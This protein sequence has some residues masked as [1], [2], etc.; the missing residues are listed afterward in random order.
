GAPQGQQIPATTGATLPPVRFPV[1][2]QPQTT[3][4]NNPA[5][6]TSETVPAMGTPAPATGTT[7]AAVTGNV[8]PF[9]P[10]TGTAPVSAAPAA[11]QNETAPQKVSPAQTTP[12]API[13]TPFPQFNG[14]SSPVSYRSESG[15]LHENTESSCVFFSRDMIIRGQ[16]PA[17]AKPDTAK[18]D[19]AK[20]DTAKPDKAKPDT[21]KPDQ[22][23]PDQ[24]KSDTV[25][26]DSVPMTSEAKK[27]AP[28]TQGTDDL[29]DS[30]AAAPAAVS[31]VSD[32]QSQQE[33][34]QVSSGQGQTGTSENSAFSERLGGRPLPLKFDPKLETTWKSLSRSTTSKTAVEVESKPGVAQSGRFLPET[35]P[36]TCPEESGKLPPYVSAKKA[37]PKYGRDGKAVPGYAP[38]EYIMDG[39]DSKGEA[40]ATPDWNVHHLDQEDTIAHFDTI[41]GRILV[42]PS[43]RVC[44]YSPRF[45]SVRQIIGL[46]ESD[47]NLLLHNAET[48]LGAV[49]SSKL[50]AV[51]VRSQ[52]E[53]VK[54][55]LVET[56]LSGMAAKDLGHS[57]SGEVAVMEN[58]Q[59]T[60]L[61]D[62][63]S[64][65]R[66]NTMSDKVK[67]SLAKGMQ[68]AQNWGSMESVK[69]AVGEVFATANTYANSP[70]TMYHVENGTK[71]AKLRLIKIASKD[72]AQPGELIEFVL[73]Y[74]NVG[75]QVIGNVTL[76][77]NLSS[78][79]V[80]VDASAKSSRKGE[81]LVK[82]NK[83]GSVVLR[84]EITEPLKPGEFG[85][86]EFICKV[87]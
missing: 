8:T 54:H 13:Q 5:V 77:D 67:A 1:E 30:P 55:T 10:P 9:L 79:L 49:S 71:S 74:E 81:F 59:E 31:K 76:L 48:A 6:K 61:G 66:L 14:F 78:R 86:V 26:A 75:D 57:M 20:P 40:Y 87:R 63:M 4:Q 33:S 44:I 68:A 7:T 25:K 28:P 52:E 22:A 72:A 34:T 17:T 15:S 42:E 11:T 82:E 64:L 60:R 45:G 12:E 62:M 38:Y 35:C 19:T 24:A 83:Q 50:A 3:G 29:F 39:S 84:W 2:Y 43:N 73:R 53:K 27:A 56:R 46:R 32:T 18:P 85:V 58:D 23:K 70:M 37:C 51:D 47:Q 21:A 69:I 41:D 80:Y 36:G 65:I 16:A